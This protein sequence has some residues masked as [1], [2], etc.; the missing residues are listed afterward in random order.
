MA[1]DT[2]LTAELK[3]PARLRRVVIAVALSTV[4]ACVVLYVGRSFVVARLAELYLLGRGVPSSIQIDRLDR[5]GLEARVRLG[6]GRAPDLAIG[7]LSVVFEDGWSLKPR[8]VTVSHAVMR[9]GFDGEKLSFGTLQRL[10]ESIVESGEAPPAVPAAPAQAPMRIVLEDAKLL[11][12]TPAGVISLAGRGVVAGRNVERFSGTI[13][14]A[15]LRSPGFALLLSGGSISARSTDKGVEMHLRARGR[16]LSVQKL[17]A[18][19]VQ[20]GLDLSGIGWSGQNLSLA[21]GVVRFSADALNGKNLSLAHTIMQLRLSAWQM[22]RNPEGTRATGT[23]NG[24]VRFE[25]GRGKGWSL[26]K[27]ALHTSASALSLQTGV[28]GWRVSGPV[29]TMVDLSSARYGLGGTPLMADQFSATLQGDIG[30]SPDGVAG[31]LTGALK[32]DLSVAPADARKAVRK[33]PLIGTDTRGR[34]TAIAALRNMHLEAPHFYIGKSAGPLVLTLPEPVTLTSRSGA[35]AKLT[36]SGVFLLSRATD[37]QMKGG[38]DATL[39]GGGLPVIDLHVPSYSARQ[40]G[41]ALALTSGVALK[42]RANMHT[43][44]ALTLETTGAFTAQNGATAYRA[45]GCPHVGVGAYLSDSTVMFSKL[46]TTICARESM[47]LFTSDEA[48]WHFA[49]SWKNLSA[50]LDAAEA[51]AKSKTGRIDITGDSHGMS[52]GIVQSH[53]AILTD[54][55]TE[56]RFVPLTATTRLVLKKAKWRGELNFASAKTG[57]KVATTTVQH[58]LRSGKGTAQISAD[59]ALSPD[60]LQ[61]AD[62][63]PLLASLSNANGRAKFR[64]TLRWTAH[65]MVSRG[66]LSVQQTN[67]T[68]PLGAI[69]QAE[70]E[71]SF[72]SLLPP[73][74]QRAQSITAQR[75]DWLVPLSDLLLKFQLAKDAVRVEAFKAAVAGG[76]IAI[77]AMEVPRDPKAT[78]SGTLTLDGVNLSALIAASNLADKVSLDARVSGEIPFRYGPDG[79]RLQNGHFASIGPARLSIRREVWTGD[80]STDKDTGKDNAIRDFA[81]QALENLA[82]DTLEAKLDSQP[83]GRLGLVFHI[84]GRNDPAKAEEARIGVF[85]LIEGKA[86]DTPLPLPKGTPVD[87]TLDTSLNFDELLEAYR[88]AFSANLAEAAARTDQ[89]KGK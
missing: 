6:G 13:G 54:A 31:T 24:A 62:L 84:K 9:L 20:L 78:M 88:H 71:I 30:L 67:L 16:G 35:R 87:L 69:K 63:S 44:R 82:I 55:K 33:L 39:S 15:N 36:Q 51:D 12:F 14:R 60:G 18:A 56:K 29:V 1:G 34:A 3:K 64:G 47:P 38:F 11:T 42:V 81:Y 80:G 52:D 85:K 68:S 89:D 50:H 58:D 83:H 5:E 41:G 45:A 27:A 61:P 65:E 4:L 75:I 43:W 79:L 23:L 2:P 77:T 49:G 59:I 40:Q 53:G 74:T 72:S 86:F 70:A 19:E 76:H 26:S 57:R 17:R 21:D 8:V 25:Q 46:R 22:E 48:G 7:H 10:V 66:T 28:A 37:G 32:S 73:V